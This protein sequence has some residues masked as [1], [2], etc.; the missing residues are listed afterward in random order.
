MSK[1]G[2]RWE[3]LQQ[4]LSLSETYA[5]LGV[6]ST[7]D[8]EDSDGSSVGELVDPA[9]LGEPVVH[10]QQAADAAG[11]FPAATVS[12]RPWSAQLSNA[13]A[14]Q[15]RPSLVHGTQNIEM[16]LKAFDPANPLLTRALRVIAR[17][18][19]SNSTLR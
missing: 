12:K 1:R 16:I 2:R 5:S 7:L 4:E 18:D 11:N 19:H 17:S 3:H 10:Q 13:G 6:D 14:L 15:L 8:D 9:E